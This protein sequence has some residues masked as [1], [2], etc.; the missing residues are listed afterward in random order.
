M[1]SYSLQ[2]NEVILYKS[3]PCNGIEIMLTNLNII[4]LK[5]TQKLFKKAQVETFVYSKDDIKVYNGVP[6][7]KQKDSSVEIFLSSEEI[8]VNFYS[9]IEAHKFVNSV[10]ELLTGKSITMRGAEKVKNAINLV[11]TTLGIDTM[12][13]VKNVMENGIPGSLLGGIGKK[14]GIKNKSSGLK[15]A[16]NVAKDLIGVA[17]NTETQTTEKA[18]DYNEKIENVKKLK[19]LLD[20]GILTQE[21]FDEKKKRLLDL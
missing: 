4:I 2:T 18:E 16:V 12:N 14:V 20:A 10:Y 13:T 19:E 8:K 7:V 6:Q 21:E 1:E 5:K 15:E 3:E 17:T 11:D 9:R